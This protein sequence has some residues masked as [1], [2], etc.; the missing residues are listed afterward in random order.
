MLVKAASEIR[1]ERKIFLYKVALTNGT[2]GDKKRF[3]DRRKAVLIFER[4]QYGV[5]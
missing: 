2:C 5:K 4:Q 3:P 1:E